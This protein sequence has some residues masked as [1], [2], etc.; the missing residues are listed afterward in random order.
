MGRLMIP[1]ALSGCTAPAGKCLARQWQE[2]GALEEMFLRSCDGKSER[3]TTSSRRKAAS[4]ADGAT[5]HAE[6]VQA[7]LSRPL[8]RRTPLDGLT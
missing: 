6:G 8:S 4:P 1:T 5:P 3:G 7:K 2:E